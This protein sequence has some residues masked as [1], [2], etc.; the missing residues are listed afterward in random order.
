MLPEDDDRLSYVSAPASDYSVTT[1][2]SELQHQSLDL[3]D[4]EI[5]EVTT[6]R[7]PPVGGIALI[8]PPK[9]S[10]Q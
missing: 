1:V 8:P 3:E 6:T 5:E 2:G 9:V 7:S 4:E 10:L